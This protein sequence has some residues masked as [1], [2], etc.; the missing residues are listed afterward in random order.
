MLN[1]GLGNSGGC[2]SG[3]VAFG[4]LRYAINQHETATATATS[5]SSAVITNAM[6]RPIID[7]QMSSTRWAA[8]CT[9]LEINFHIIVKS[10]QF[11]R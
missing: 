10:I 5:D 3:P 7:T 9:E 8:G 2:G 6:I 1:S 4:L 11:E